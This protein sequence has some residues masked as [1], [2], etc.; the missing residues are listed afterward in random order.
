M[1]KLDGKVA[2]ITGAGSGQGLAGA[3][4]FAKEG[5]QVVVG[6]F[7]EE[8]GRAAAEEIAAAGGQAVFAHCDV[9]KE[10]EVKAMVDLA[11]ATYGRVDVLYNNAGLWLSARGNYKPGITDAPSP[12]LED[13]IWE[14]TVAVN[15]K[16]VYLGAKYAIPEMKKV[17]A[18]AIIN[19]SSVAAVKTG[20]EATRTPTRPPR[21]ASWPSPAPLPSSTPPSR[22]GATASFPAPSTHPWPVPS[23][24]STRR[25]SRT[26]SLSAAG[27]SPRTWRSWRSSWPATTPRG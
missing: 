7:T 5:A 15:L 21:A 20:G 16:S 10:A 12:L 22:S 4:L 3:R 25:R 19:V 26:R 1:G 11:V 23:R 14:R 8:T 17:G 13:N 6:E 2:I 18:G 24:L 27:V 9:G